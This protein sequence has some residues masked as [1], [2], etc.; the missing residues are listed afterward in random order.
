[1]RN[2]VARSIAA[3]LKAQLR[4]RGIDCEY[5]RRGSQATTTV[6]LIPAES[7]FDV[8]ENGRMVRSARRSDFI[9]LAASLVIDD[10]RIVPHTGDEITWHDSENTETRKYKVSPPDGMRP[11]DYGDPYRVQLRIRCVQAE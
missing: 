8:D 1:M 11:Y 6:R 4:L 10:V 9:A 3:A 2:P 5:R 7:D